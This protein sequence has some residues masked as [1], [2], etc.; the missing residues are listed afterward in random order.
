MLNKVIIAYA[1]ELIKN[2]NLIFIKLKL[3]GKKKRIIIEKLVEL[4]RKDIANTQ[5]KYTKFLLKTKIKEIIGRSISGKYRKKEEYYNQK[6]IQKY[7][8]KNS[9]IQKLLDTEFQD[10][11]FY[12]KAP[13]D[14][15]DPIRTRIKKIYEEQLKKKIEKN[16]KTIEENIENFVEMINDRKEKGT[17]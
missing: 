17:K 13:N 12:I 11:F 1:N 16:R 3:D 10:F 15:N 9:E 6:I 2:H 4:N 8:D 14:P 5:V 7:Y